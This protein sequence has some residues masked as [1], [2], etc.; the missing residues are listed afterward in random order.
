[1][2]PPAADVNADEVVNVADL[3]IVRNN[4]GEGSGCP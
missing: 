4:L 2:I 1:M 3:L